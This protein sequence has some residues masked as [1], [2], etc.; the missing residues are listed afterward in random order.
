MRLLD[1]RSRLFGVVNPV[2]LVV[3]LLLLVMALVVAN[4]LFGRTPVVSPGTGAKKDM[5]VVL[6]AR[7][8]LTYDPA[9]VKK[10]ATVSKVGGSGTMG[11]LASI[12][13]KPAVHEVTDDTGAVKTVESQL[14]KDVYLTVKGKGTLTDDAVSIGDEQI[15]QNMQLDVMTSKYQL[16]VRVLS[17]KVTE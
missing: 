6:V 11:K 10:G 1:D 5:E 15:R 9:Y 17:Y 13:A 16:Q 2:D 4:V 12:E 7:D 14:Y 3:V 8:L